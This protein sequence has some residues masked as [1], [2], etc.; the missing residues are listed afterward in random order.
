[1]NC[2]HPGTLIGNGINN[3]L[4]NGRQAALPRVLIS[5]E[6]RCWCKYVISKIAGQEARNLLGFL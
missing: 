6:N 3:E 1:M 5:E 2:V 4:I